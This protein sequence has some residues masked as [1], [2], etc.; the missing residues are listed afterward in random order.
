MWLLEYFMLCGKRFLGQAIS[1]F[2][3]LAAVL[4]SANL[5]PAETVNPGVTNTPSSAASATKSP[6]GQTHA[7]KDALNQERERIKHRIEMIRMWGLVSEL[8]LDAGK[9]KIFFPIINEYQQ[10]KNIA[11]RKM[12]EIRVRMAE[13]LSKDGSS[14]Q[15][16]QR[17]I[18]EYSA[19]AS[20]QAKLSQEEFN[21]LG[22]ILTLRQQAQYI[23]FGDR[24]NRELYFTIRQAM[25]ENIV[26]PAKTKNRKAS[27]PPAR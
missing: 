12:H 19:A 22:E 14:S 20:E 21:K 9:A 15:D 11:A 7:V 1:I 2:I 24:F 27:S 16:I 3:I 23:L 5:A 6:S 8:N 10:R 25:D 18:N 26:K 4:L 17:L 13:V